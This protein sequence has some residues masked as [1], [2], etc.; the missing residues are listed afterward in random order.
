MMWPKRKPKNRRLERASVL[1]VKL[2]SSQVRAARVRLLGVIFGVV[3][4]GL[5]GACL[6]W[7]GAAWAMRV[8][9]YENSAFAIE[10]LDAQTDGII[11]VDQLRRWTGVKPGENLLALDTARLQRDLKMVSVIQSVSVE[12]ILPHTLR[13]RVTEREPIA[14]VNVLRPGDGGRICTATFQLDGEG[15]VIV[16]LEPRQRAAR[17]SASTDQLPLIT[18]LNPNEVQAGRRIDLPQV[19]AALDLVTAFERSPMEGLTDVQMIDVSQPEALVVTTS[20]GSR[21]TFGCRRLDEQL[22]RWRSVFDFGQQS[23]RVIATMDLAITSSVPVV[24]QDAGN[25]P[26]STPKSLKRTKRKHV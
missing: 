3:F 24:F 17:A 12:R 16:P 20:Q 1:D 25:V 26:L 10:V 8:L 5:A 13:V 21:I 15:Y 2:R 4:G 7:Y 11:A 23:N 22:R 6:L 19:H 18:G 9:V 14:Q